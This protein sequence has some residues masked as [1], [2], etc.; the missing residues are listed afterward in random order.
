MIAGA[1]WLWAAGASAATLYDGLKCYKVKDDSSASAVVDLAPADAVTFGSDAGCSVKVRGRELCV[2]VDPDVTQSSA[3]LLPVDGAGLAADYACHALKCPAAALPATLSLSSRLGT[4]DFAGLKVASLC[5]P[6]VREALPA[7]RGASSV[8]R[9]AGIHDHLKCFKGKGLASVLA[10]LDLRPLDSDG[11]P[12]DAGCTI[13]GGARSL[14]IPVATQ[15]QQSS[16][17]PTDVQGA[18]LEGAFLC[19]AMRCPD[20]LLPSALAV[21]DS[22]GSRTL[23]GLRTSTICLPAVQ[24]VPPSTT[25]TTTT[26]PSGT[27]RSCVDA[28]PPNCDGTC[29]DYN[30]ACV[31]DNGACKCL[32][33]D[34]FAPCPMAGHGVPECWGSCDGS[35]TCLQVGDACQCGLA[36]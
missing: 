12:V 9:A 29:N 24:G 15:V 28:T 13:K 20:A 31:A 35:N 30:Q 21:R 5:A 23:T 25:T 32:Y 3:A 17:P 1:A 27:P 8:P 7:P 19:Y 2:P 10:T 18:D 26:L 22:F 6:S 4:T 34:V 11:F 16:T 33:V 14:C 36:Y